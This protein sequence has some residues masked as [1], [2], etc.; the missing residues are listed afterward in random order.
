[1]DFIDLSAQQEIIRDKIE[2][3]IK[4]VLTHGRYIMGP[5]VFE[6]EEK[7]KSYI[8]IRHCISCSSGTDALIIPLMAKGIGPGDA[9]ITTSFSYIATAEV[10]AL[11]GAT[12]IFCDIYPETFNINPNGLDEA[13]DK[14]VSE[15]LTPKAIISVDLFGLPARY[16]LIDEFAKSKNLFL[17]EDGAQGFGGKINERKACTL[18][19]VSSTS[20]FP[21]KPLGGYGDGGAIFTNNDELAE[22][23]RSIRVHGGGE[24]KYDNVRL[25]LNG[26][27]DTLQAAI[28]IEKLAIF[29]SELIMRNKVA[30]YFSKNLNPNFA[31][32]YVPDN[33]FSSWAQYSVLL[34]DEEEREK[35]IEILN[36]KKIPSM[37]YYKIPLHLQK[38]FR[39]LNYKKGDLPNSESIANKIISLPMH[40]YLKRSDQD[41][42]INTMNY[43]YSN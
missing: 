43:L 30:K 35:V 36:Y 23:M 10:I 29:D 19:D 26:R 13:Y 31:L 22:N 8:G 39:N 38:V 11:L 1:V 34:K 27:L 28:L 21:A 5:E 6:L 4:D 33:Y 32:P 9:V 16:R 41:L 40:P 12:P 15:G 20:F 24:D 7:L 14:A 25:G 17:L 3:R 2:K 37:I 42:I 18:G